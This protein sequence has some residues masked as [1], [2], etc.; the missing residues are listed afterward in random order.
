MRN[1]FLK[2]IISVLTRSSI[3]VGGQAVINGVMMR[4]PGA[5]ATAVR[6]D[7]GKIQT[8]T[9][10]FKS[11]IQKNKFLNIPII[12]GAVNLFEALK[13]GYKTLNWSSQFVEE[14]SKSNFFIE[15][16]MNLVAILFALSLFFL[17]P[18]YCAGLITESDSGN[19]IFFNVV[20]GSAR[21]SIFI[22]YLFLISC[23]KD[24]QTLFQYHGAEHKTI[25]AF[26]SGNELSYDSAKKFK[27]EH[28]RCGTSFLFI[29]MLVS[30]FSYS[31]ID[32]IA[33]FLLNIDLD[34]FKRTLLHLVCLPFV[35][36]VSYE[37]LKLIAQNIEKNV[38]LKILA[39]PGLMLQKITTKEPTK[40]QLEVAFK[41]LIVAFGDN[42]QKH[43]GKK[44]KADAIG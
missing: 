42:Y 8:M 41:S 40:D 33:I 38:F 12:R 34:V 14:D 43:K 16:L 11:Y 6:L 25:Y 21:I 24:V 39:R 27:K 29:V 1:F 28:P 18:I 31:V 19:A 3:L 36:G 26:E 13:I 4:V 37:V 35:A 23:L 17:L 44:Y 22:L 5:Y 10:P 2:S 7:D 15:Q 20:A 9:V 30:I 32:S